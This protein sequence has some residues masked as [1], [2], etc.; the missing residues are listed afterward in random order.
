MASKKQPTQTRESFIGGE[1]RRVQHQPVVSNAL[2]IKI[3][4]LKTF[5]P[6]TEN[7][8]KF[9]EIYRGGGYFTFLLGSP[10]TGKSFIA[11]Y[12]ALEEVLDRDTPFKQLVIVRSAVQTRDVG[13]LPGTLEEKSEL[14]EMPYME[15]CATLFG[16]SDAYQRLKEQGYVRFI[17]TTAIRGISIDD[18]IIMVDETQNMTWQE[19]STVTTRVGHRSKIIFCG[20]RGQNDLVKTRN[21]QSGLAQFLDVARTMKAYQEVVF[22]PEDIVRSSLV[23]DFIIACES[24][25]LLPGN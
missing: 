19:I 13:F 14:Y 24:K 21:D 11:A 15:I 7:Q 23:R 22:T 8:E 25:G 16:R 20:D 6:L 5:E 12:K 17:T 1:D 10:G 18:A 3:D 4:H 9:F 2:K